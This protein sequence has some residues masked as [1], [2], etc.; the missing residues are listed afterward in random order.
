MQHGELMG[1]YG[2][3]RHFVEVRLPSDPSI[4]REKDNFFL[5]CK[6]LDIIVSAK[7]RSMPMREAGIRLR[8]ILAAHMQTHK[9]LH[10]SDRVK[11]KMHW[12]FDIAECM[13]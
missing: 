3:F 10:G 1:L 6:A 8:D 2:L 4:A 13:I 5:I 9:C 12:A 7:G 11:P